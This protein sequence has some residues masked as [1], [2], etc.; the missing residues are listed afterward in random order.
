MAASGLPLSYR[1]VIGVGRGGGGGGAEE[2]I[3][4]PLLNMW[5]LSPPIEH[6]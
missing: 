2:T 3:V 4:P 6:E 1:Q 5:G